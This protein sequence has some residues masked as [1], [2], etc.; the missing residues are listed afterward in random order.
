MRPREAHAREHRHRPR[1]D[2]GLP[3]R[4]GALPEHARRPALRP[5][6]R[7]EL[8]RLRRAR[9][10]RVLRA[11]AHR[12]GAADD[13]AADAA[14]LPRGVRGAGR[15]RADLLAPHLRRSCRAPSPARRSRRGRPAPTASG[16]STPSRRPSAIAM[17]ALDGPAAARARDDRRGDRGAVERH[18]SETRAPLHGRHARVPRQG[19]PDRARAGARRQPAEREADPRRSRTARSCRSPVCAAARRRST[20]FRKRFEAAT[21]DGPGLRV[22][23]A[24]AEAP[25]TVEAIARRSC[26]RARPRPRSSS[27]TMLGAVVGT[28]AGPGTVG[29]FWFQNGA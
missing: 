21:T 24:H 29:F 23:I 6:R 12:A 4:A 27:S 28:H 2:G 16:S 9:P 17:L 26:W 5:L 14:G 11:A 22:G 3:R 15:L 10:G 20:E 25:E 13:L 7:G 18:R 8:P 19:R 1:L